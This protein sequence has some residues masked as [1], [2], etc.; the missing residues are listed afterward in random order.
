MI[1]CANHRHKIIQQFFYQKCI[2]TQTQKAHSFY[3]KAIIICNINVLIILP[4]GCWKTCALSYHMCTLKIVYLNPKF[5]CM[6]TRMFTSLWYAFQRSTLGDNMQLTFQRSAF[7]FYLSD[8]LWRISG[9]IFALC[10][11]DAHS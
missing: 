3:I 5:P 2:F 7:F 11:W 8:V 1:T 10:V 4:N 6:F 9:C